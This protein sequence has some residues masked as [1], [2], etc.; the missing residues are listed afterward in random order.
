MIVKGAVANSPL[1]DQA[2]DLTS[3]IQL[4]PNLILPVPLLATIGYE[5]MPL[6]VDKFV[7]L[8]HKDSLIDEVEEIE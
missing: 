1:A 6:K 2:E 4:I 7:Q 3:S 5:R 8:D